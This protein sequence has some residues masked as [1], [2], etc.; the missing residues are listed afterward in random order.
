MNVTEHLMHIQRSIPDC[1]AAGLVDPKSGSVIAS[2]TR[3]AARIA[4]LE[5]SAAEVA[6]VFDGAHADAIENDGAEAGSP[7][8]ELVLVT[9]GSIRMFQRCRLSP[10][11]MLVTVAGASSNLGGTI[12]RSRQWL[13]DLEAA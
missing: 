1:T 12:A 7:L 3:S 5:L 11:L 9:G 10:G 6:E 2:S 4:E 13:A 8:R